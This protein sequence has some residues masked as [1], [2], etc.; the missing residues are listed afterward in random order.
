MTL[1]NAFSIFVLVMIIAVLLPI[2]ITFINGILGNVDPTTALLLG[3]I[4]VALVIGVLKTINAYSAPY[5]AYLRG[6]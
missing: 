5:Q 2:M 3:L 6:Q 4:P 1:D